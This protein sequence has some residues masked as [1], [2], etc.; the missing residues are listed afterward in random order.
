MPILSPALMLLAAD[1]VA[2]MVAFPSSPITTGS[3]IL[4]PLLSTAYTEVP[5]V[6]STGISNASGSLSAEPDV[7]IALM[8]PTLVIT[9]FGVTLSKPEFT[10]TGAFC[11]L[12]AGSDVFAVTGVLSLIEDPL[13]TTSLF[14]VIVYSIPASLAFSAVPS[15]GFNLLSSPMVKVNS[16]GVLVSPWLG[17]TPMLRFS[18]FLRVSPLSPFALTVTSFLPPFSPTLTFGVTGAMLS[19]I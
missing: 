14:G 12:P 5:G 15:A 16:T 6:P 9:S 10:V 18:P 17:T 3:L 19:P 2:L 8:S 1:S 7:L 4:L 13:I 11:V